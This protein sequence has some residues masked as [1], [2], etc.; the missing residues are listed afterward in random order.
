MLL[1]DRIMEY[2]VNLGVGGIVTARGMKGMADSAVLTRNLSAL[3]AAGRLMRIARGL[4][5]VPRS[6]DDGHGSSQPEGL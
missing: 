3:A 6:A 1:A 2:A 5:V 4:Y